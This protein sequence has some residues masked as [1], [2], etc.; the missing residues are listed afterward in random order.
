M[1]VSR[2]YAMCD[3]SILPAQG[4]RDDVLI[5]INE[6]SDDSCEVGKY[7][8]SQRNLGQSNVIKV[9][10]PATAVI[11]WDQFERLRDQVMLGLRQRISTDNPT[12]TLASCADN[13]LYCPEVVEQVRQLTQ[14]R[15][16]VTTRGIA[17]R[18]HGIPTS[19]GGSTKHQHVEG[20]V[21]NYL[22]IWLVNYFENSLQFSSANQ[23]ANNRKDAFNNGIDMRLVEPSI[24]YELIIGRIDGIDVD[25]ANALV[26]R[27]INAEGKG[28]FGK[29]HSH[30]STNMALSGYVPDTNFV[31]PAA[32]VKYGTNSVGDDW[33]Y[34]LGMFNETDNACA[35][36]RDNGTPFYLGISSAL[37]EGKAPFGCH[38]KLH[39][40]HGTS[41]EPTPANTRSR[42]PI[43]DDA[44]IYQGHT[45]GQATSGSFSA[46]LNWR[47]GETQGQCEWRPGCTDDANAC[48]ITLCAETSNVAA[49]QAASTDHFKE[50]DTRCVGVSDGFIGYNF[51]SWP[52]SFYAVW[53]T[54][55]W[56]NV[57]SSAEGWSAQV[58]GDNSYRGLPIADVLDSQDGDD[59]SFWLGNAQH[60][61]TD[62]CYIDDS[63]SAL[64]S[65]QERFDVHVETIIDLD[66]EKT[67]LADTTYALEFWYKTHDIPFSSSR[68]VSAQVF[69]R[70]VDGN[71]SNKDQVVYTAQVTLLDN[72]SPAQLAEADGQWQRARATFSIKPE[73]HDSLDINGNPV[74]YN[75]DKLKLRIFANV[76][77]GG[78]LGLDAVTV[79][80]TYEGNS[81]PLNLSNPSFAGGYQQVAYGDH[82]ANFL[83]R[84]NGTAFWGS[85]SHHLT[86]GH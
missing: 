80:E 17:L 70:P 46:M 61:P 1:G 32:D 77:T 13:S 6:N 31:G 41:S 28:L 43:V 11:E 56:Q 83:N 79:I 64:S 60:A 20:S 26:D 35:G 78:K 54:G 53:P 85:V 42:T 73:L 52:V 40:A 18:V 22:R 4:V 37:S 67:P 8:A 74:R 19:S 69:A 21:D 16:L 24:D 57:N 14:I 44:L 65:C 9:K 15:Y 23:Y 49:C 30:A 62:T 25:G 59:A 71:T 55:W 47:K 27:A 72:N 48:A 3:E 76:D 2:A 7:Y 58:G 50:I 10:L 45:D 39:K 5:I 36:W 86:G 29:L 63:L 33:R 68:T 82:A 84:L 38:V 51:Q 12:L 34:Q 81:S 75:Y 66:G